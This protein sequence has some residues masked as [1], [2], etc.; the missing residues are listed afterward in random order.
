MRL[1]IR[2]WVSVSVSKSN[3]KSRIF[4]T[5]SDTYFLF[6]WAISVNLLIGP[7]YVQ[8]CTDTCRYDIY[9]FI[10]QTFQYSRWIRYS[11]EFNAVLILQAYVGLNYT[12]ET[13]TLNDLVK[14]I[15]N[16]MTMLILRVFYNC[17]LYLLIPFAYISKKDLSKSLQ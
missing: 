6:Y 8:M 7:L 2:L 4:Q 5:Y 11:C 10:F 14:R 12:N 16:L 15:V 9:I 17:Q 13:F 1:K 3:I